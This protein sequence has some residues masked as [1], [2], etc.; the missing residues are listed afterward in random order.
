[1]PK[2]KKS[3][4]KK[5][6][7]SSRSPRK[8]KGRA[9]S[10][11]S[12]E[13]QAEPMGLKW[14]AMP[15]PGW[16]FDFNPNGPRNSD[17]SAPFVL[18]DHDDEQE[19][20]LAITE[21]EFNAGLAGS[22]SARSNVPVASSVSTSA[23]SQ[24]ASSSRS[25]NQQTESQPVPMTIK[26]H[27]ERYGCLTHEAKTAV[28][29]DFIIGRVGRTYREIPDTDENNPFKCPI[30]LHLKTHPVL[31]PCGHMFCALCIRSW[32]SNSFECPMCKTV[33]LTAPIAVPVINSMIDSK[34]SSA[35]Y[36]VKYSINWGRLWRGI[37]FPK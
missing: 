12:E 1:M 26:E 18:I 11:S 2:S 4:P 34:F 29:E 32:L 14:M 30:C 7:T 20:I 37:T 9:A 13:E 22:A 15:P 5:K 35:Q 10:E 3:S 36:R 23:S 17:K 31:A 28:P 16:R 8:K 25:R 21:E 19:E 6:E 24:P 33:M 27:F